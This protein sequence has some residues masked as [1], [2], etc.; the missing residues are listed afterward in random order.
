MVHEKTIG[1]L[2]AE[3]YRKAEVFKKYGIDFCCGGKKSVKEVCE[4]KGID[5]ATL[6]KELLQT[7]GGSCSIGGENFNAWQLEKLI[8]YIIEKH[9][10][11]VNR[12]LPLLL[13]YSQKVA[14]VHGNS[15]PE[16]VKIAGLVSQLADEMYQHMMKE[17]RVLFPYIKEL[18]KTL[19]SGGHPA[20][21]PFGT[22]KN[23]V[24]MMEAEHE[25]AGELLRQIG[26]LSNNFTPPE[27]ACNTYRVE[28]FKLKE[29]EDDL[30]RHVHL[31]NN[32]LFPKAVEMEGRLN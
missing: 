23:P 30:H 1:E 6:E 19:T 17:E 31:E 2:V 25:Q 11:Y 22:V 3:D 20:Q 15:N 18:E 28:Y 26:I 9:H 5:F 13:E 4:K 12:S 27:H 21:P 14:T 10:T 7:E 24:A 16:T 32:I 29:F 8:D